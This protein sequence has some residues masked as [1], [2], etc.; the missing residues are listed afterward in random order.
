MSPADAEGVAGWIGVDLMT[1]FG[2]KIRRGPEQTCTEGHDLIVRPT[3]VI[4]VEVEVDLLLLGA[5]RPLWC[6]VVRGPL[7]SDAPLPGGVN[8]TVEVVIVVDDVPADD[9]GPES[10]LGRGVGGVQHDDAPDRLHRRDTS[11]G[12]FPKRRSGRDGR[13]ESWP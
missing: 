10:T 4:D 5:V 13:H 12:D 11:D 8:D 1:F 2:V 7:D 9:T 3:D 6:D